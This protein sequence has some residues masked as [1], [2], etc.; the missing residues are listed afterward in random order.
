MNCQQAEPLLGSYLEGQ[1]ELGDRAW[2]AVSDH[3]QGCRACSDHLDDLRWVIAQVK[4]QPRV[5]APADLAAKLHLRLA[6]EPPPRTASLWERVRASLNFPS[7][8][9]GAAVAAALMFVVLR[10]PQPQLGIQVSAV[11]IDQDVA[12]QI[13]FD[14]GEDVSDVTFDVQLQDGLKFIDAKGQPTTT[15]NVT[16]KGSLKRG[17][18]VVPVTVR[19]IRPG[20]WE[21]LATVRKDQLARRTQII[22]PVTGPDG[23]QSYM[24]RSE[25]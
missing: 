3:V 9:I 2:S 18:T 7:L 4:A 25:G 5:K 8:G 12:V 24:I 11:P 19:G 22:I 23:K 20:R 13:A 17:T 15:Q 16:W 10:G 6:M 14:V 1:A 21:I